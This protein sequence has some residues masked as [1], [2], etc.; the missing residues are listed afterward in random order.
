MQT[1]AS[2]DPCAQ[3][4]RGLLLLMLP[5]VAPFGAALMYTESRATLSCLFVKSGGGGGTDDIRSHGQGKRAGSEGE[6]PL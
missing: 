5:P 4:G 6:M 1:V 3:I 2:G